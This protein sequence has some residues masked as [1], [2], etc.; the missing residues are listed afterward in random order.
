M[1]ISGF[2]MVRNAEKY[3][4]PIKA[5]IESVLPIVDEFIV[6]LGVGEDKT[7]EI[8]ESINSP[9]VKIIE[10]VWDER[11]FVDGEIFRNETN[12]AM[13]NCKGEWCFYLQADEVVHEKYL[14]KIKEMCE[15]YKNKKEVEGFLFQYKHFWGDYDHYLDCHGWYPKEIRIV[16]N[17]IGVKSYK[18]A[19]SFRIEDRK[20]NVIDIPCYI[21]H[22]GWVRPPLVMTPK[23]KEQDSMHW[24]KD[25]ADKEYLSRPDLFNYGPLGQ[26]PIYKD[27]HPMV[28]KEWMKDFHWKEQLNYGREYNLNREP[29]K[30]ERLK[31]K[32]I[33]A[34]EKIFNGGNQIGGF[35]NY[36][37]VGRER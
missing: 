16:R 14:E 35:R 30:H 12:F 17:N 19:Q 22:Y 29:M 24:G 10:R 26:L 25:K 15:K 13:D 37:I 33:T 4:F 6:A 36:H 34:F 21:Y 20:L 27:S 8:I 1:L 7:K 5:A 9:K 3:Y 23:K 32:I 28:M 2:T 31:Y 11:L 18:D